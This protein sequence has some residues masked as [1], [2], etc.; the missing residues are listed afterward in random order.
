MTPV[1]AK[2]DGKG[3]GRSQPARPHGSGDETGQPLLYGLVAIRCLG[4]AQANP[5]DQRPHAGDYRFNRRLIRATANIVA[6]Y[7]NRY[8]LVARE[9]PGFILSV[10]AALRA[11]VDG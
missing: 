10:H 3:G 7:V 5:G 11:Q 2:S 8:P 9:L 6:H 1:R 4:Q